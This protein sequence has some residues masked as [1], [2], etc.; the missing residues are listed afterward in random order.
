VN[1]VKLYG[2]LRKVARRLAFCVIVLAVSGLVILFTVE[3]TR[4]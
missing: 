2:I 1:R 4:V 3:V